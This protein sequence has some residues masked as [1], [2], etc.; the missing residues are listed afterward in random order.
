MVVN[1]LKLLFAGS[2][3]LCAAPLIGGCVPDQGPGVLSAQPYAAPAPARMYQAPAA[4]V[5]PPVYSPT[6]S[7]MGDLGG[8]RGSGGGGSRGGGGGGGGSASS[9]GGSTGGG[10]G[11]GSGGGSGGGG[12]GGGGGWGG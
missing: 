10:G 5:P 9:G 11:G 7:P 1:R 6:Y 8:G 12:G 3:C 2:L 4:Y